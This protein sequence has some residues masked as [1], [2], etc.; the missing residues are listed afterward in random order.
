METVV[1]AETTFDARNY[2]DQP[3]RPRRLRQRIRRRPAIINQQDLDDIRDQQEDLIQQRQLQDLQ[4]QLLN[5]RWAQQQEELFNQLVQQ[6]Q[7]QESLN[8]LRQR[9]IQLQPQAQA[10]QP[11]PQEQQDTITALQQQ[12]TQEREK[13]VALQNQNRESQ[14][15]NKEIHREQQAQREILTEP[16]S[17]NTSSVVGDLASAVVNL[18]SASASALGKLASSGVSTL[19]VKPLKGAADIIKSSVT[20]STTSVSSSDVFPRVSSSD[21]FPGLVTPNQ[22]G[23]W[24]SSHP[25]YYMTGSPYPMEYQS[26]LASQS[27]AIRSA[28]Q[29]AQLMSVPRVQS[30]S[31]NP[32]SLPSSHLTLSQSS[33]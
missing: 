12:L 26:D 32:S 11:Q 22:T 16:V 18:S 9:L 19:V 25:S 23:T 1:T 5:Q 3:Q 17:S 33:G 28:Q 6:Q 13:T 27:A 14:R 24:P 4:Q 7:K 10:Q 2:V 31:F 15:L 30:S 8:Q 29:A 20:P 21:V